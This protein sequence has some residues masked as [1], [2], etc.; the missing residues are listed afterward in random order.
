MHKD[1]SSVAQKLPDKSFFCRLNP[2]TNVHDAV[3]NDVI[4]NDAC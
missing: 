3:T 1:G 2:I 4:N